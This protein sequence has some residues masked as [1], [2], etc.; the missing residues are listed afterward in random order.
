MSATEKSRSQSRILFVKNI[1]YTTTGAD[2]Y[3]LFGKYGAIRQIRIGDG[4]KTKGTAF[5]AFEEMVDA[6]NALD[7][8]NG[9]HLQERYIVGE[10]GEGGDRMVRW[11]RKLTGGCLLTR[12]TAFCIAQCYITSH[13]DRPQKLTWQRGKLISRR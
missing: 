4:P 8:L 3:E 13:R 6:K 5:V 12:C 11:L 1:N 9:Y 10:Y 2:L 7:H